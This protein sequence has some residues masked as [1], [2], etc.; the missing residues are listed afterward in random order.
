MVTIL[1]NVNALAASRQLGVTKIDLNKT[2]TR[3]TTGRRVNTA[4]DDAASLD[5]GNTAMAA[6]RSAAASVYKSQAAYFV[7]L[8][9]DGQNQQLTE[10]AYKM[11]ELEGGG[12]TGLQEYSDLVTATGAA[13]STLALASIAA[14]QKTNAAA[15]SKALSDAQLS[16]IQAE[17]QLGIADSYL[18]ADMGAEM[19][20]L[21]KYQIMMQAGT[22]ALSNANQSA[23][24]ILGLFR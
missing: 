3:L 12:N 9:T 24:T 11:A 8:N 10:L 17:T 22:S 1:S 5:A 18:G 16:G 23:Q 4:S 21:T 6:S 19:A 15:M 7:A 2:I 13:S 14:S 20:N